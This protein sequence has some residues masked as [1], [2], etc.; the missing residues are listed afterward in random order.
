MG[1]RG[2]S[3]RSARRIEKASGRLWRLP[4]STWLTREDRV[5]PVWARGIQPLLRSGQRLTAVSVFKEM[6][7]RSP[8]RYAQGGLGTP[9][10]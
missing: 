1:K 6:Q 9:Q 8:D 3:V 4:R 5:E 10:R 2:I 7:R